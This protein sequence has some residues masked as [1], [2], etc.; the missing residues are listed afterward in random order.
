M[1]RNVRLFFFGIPFKSH[2]FFTLSKYGTPVN[3]E[4]QYHFVG[5]Q[6]SLAR[7]FMIMHKSWAARVNRCND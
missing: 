3:I 4:F 5:G 1:L 6:A 2:Q 7:Q